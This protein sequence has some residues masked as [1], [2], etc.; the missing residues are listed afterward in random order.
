MLPPH[1]LETVQE[2]WTAAFH[3]DSGET[4]EKGNVENKDTKDTHTH[5]H[6][7]CL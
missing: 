6:G 7:F 1:K 3:H 4:G 2:P 5:T